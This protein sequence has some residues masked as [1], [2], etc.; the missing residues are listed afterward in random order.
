MDAVREDLKEIKSDISE[1]GS[2]LLDEL[3][4]SRVART[5]TVKLFLEPKVFV[6]I[7]VLIGLLIAAATGIG[8]SWGDLE[9]RGAGESPIHIDHHDTSKKSKKEKKANG[10]HASRGNP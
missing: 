5:E 3:R 8:V 6:P 1:L 9:V 2:E 10:K 7:L 4:A